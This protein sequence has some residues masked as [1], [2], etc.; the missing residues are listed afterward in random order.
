MND[1]VVRAGRFLLALG[2]IALTVW[3]LAE[4]FTNL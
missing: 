2:L 3:V 1:T 4:A